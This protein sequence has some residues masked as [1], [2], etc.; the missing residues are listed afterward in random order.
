MT[1][2]AECPFC[3]I[4]RGEDPARIVYR[5]RR[6]TAFFPL[7]PATRGH[8][9]I[10]PERH[11]SEIV[12]LLPQEGRD[13]ADVIGRVARALIQSLNPQGLNPMAMQ[14][15]K[16]CRTCTFI[17]FLVG[18]MTPW[19]SSGPTNPQRMESPKTS[20]SRKYEEL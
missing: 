10:V 18:Q 6:V 14:R 17:W 8:T 4:I 2:A 16:P 15:P 1:A 7:A 12:G 3:S 9:L 11:V 19:V 13:L 5:D 20:P